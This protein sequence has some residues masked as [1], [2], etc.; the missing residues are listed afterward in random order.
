[1]IHTHSDKVLLSSAR[2]QS[3]RP[4]AEHRNSAK[5]CLCFALYVFSQNSPFTSYHIYI[6]NWDATRLRNRPFNFFHC[7]LLSEN[8]I[9][10]FVLWQHAALSLAETWW[11][12]QWWL[13]SKLYRLEVTF[14]LV[15][16]LISSLDPQ[17]YWPVTAPHS[18]HRVKNKDSGLDPKLRIKVI[19]I[20]Y[21][22]PLTSYYPDNH[23]I[24]SSFNYVLETL[25][26][27]FNH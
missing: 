7:G 4:K 17:T 15:H 27:F 3:T 13:A 22:T 5:V 25:W 2:A 8:I 20:R 26:F 16:H 12:M 9:S 6:S 11:Y 19:T 14:L 18:T 21:S 24:F 23:Q 1:M 10:S